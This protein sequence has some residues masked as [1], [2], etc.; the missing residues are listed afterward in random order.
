MCQLVTVNDNTDIPLAHTP[1]ASGRLVWRL[2]RG[3][4]AKNSP[5]RGATVGSNQRP[6][7]LPVFVHDG[8]GRQVG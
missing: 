4:E 3:L 5:A 2:R 6:G 1:F 7:I 8:V